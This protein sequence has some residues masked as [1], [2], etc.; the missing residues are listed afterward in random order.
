MFVRC[1]EVVTRSELLLCVLCVCL[2]PRRVPQHTVLNLDILDGLCSLV[3]LFVII[4]LLCC[5]SMA[6][7]GGDDLH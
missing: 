7:V 1:C 2:Q 6:A 3:T 5:V 4:R